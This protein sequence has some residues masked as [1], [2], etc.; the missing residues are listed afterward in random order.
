MG[1][2]EVTNLGDNSAATCVRPRAVQIAF[3]FQSF[4]DNYYN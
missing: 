1:G 3:P 2:V 4:N